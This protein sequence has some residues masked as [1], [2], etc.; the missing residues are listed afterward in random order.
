[1]F[2]DSPQNGGDNAAG[3]RRA[4]RSEPADAEAKGQALEA[5]KS[6]L[7]D[8]FDRDMEFRAKELERVRTGLM[9]MAGQLEKRANAKSGIIALQLQ[10]IINEADGLG[11]FSGGGVQAEWPEGAP[12]NLPCPR[13]E[14]PV[15]PAQ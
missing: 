11:F 6:G 5:L 8:Y 2:R 9:K 15:A 3:S 13:T 12:L 1:L 7:E 10:M 4:E 14:V